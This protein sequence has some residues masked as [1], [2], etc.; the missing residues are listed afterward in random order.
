[1]EKSLLLKGSQPGLVYKPTTCCGTY[2]WNAPRHTNESN[3]GKDH[4]EKNDPQG[5][6]PRVFGIFP[7][8]RYYSRLWETSTVSWGKATLMLCGTY[9]KSWGRNGL[10]GLDGLNHGDEQ[11]CC[12]DFRRF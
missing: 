8:I 2:Y 6:F 5:A 11:D 10:E 4:D 12:G 7:M 9:K 3:C 1:M